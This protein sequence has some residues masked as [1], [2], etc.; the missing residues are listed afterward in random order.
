MGLPAIAKTVTR[1]SERG[2]ASKRSASEPI[3]PR[4]MRVAEVVYITLRIKPPSRK[5][6]SA[7]LNS[8]CRWQLNRN[9]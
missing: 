3:V 4:V 7:Y 5:S 9:T 6:L 1:G 2:S 8:G